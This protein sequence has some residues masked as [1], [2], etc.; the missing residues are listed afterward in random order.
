MSNNEYVS[1]REDIFK[2][3]TYTYMVLN[4]FAKF[5]CLVFARAWLP[6]KQQPSDSPRY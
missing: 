6:P 5:V 2:L 3:S 1:I 4:L